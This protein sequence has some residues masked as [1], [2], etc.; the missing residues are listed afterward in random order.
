[1]NKAHIRE[2][3][4][5]HDDKALM[6]MLREQKA[7]RN[8]CTETIEFIDIVEAIMQEKRDIVDEVLNDFVGRHRLK[9]N[10]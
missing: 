7:I 5:S 2:I 10:K 3:L 6:S 1:M 4:E 9:N 8:K